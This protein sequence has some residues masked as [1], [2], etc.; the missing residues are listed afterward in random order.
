MGMNLNAA[1]YL[2]QRGFLTQRKNKLLD[3]G[4][5]NIYHVTEQQIVQFLRNQGVIDT[6]KVSEEINR[7][8]YFSTPRPDE[9]T[10]LLS[11]ITDLA[12][13]EYNSIDVCP[14]L[15]TEILDL[16]FDQIPA[17]L[18]GRYDVVLNFGTTEHIFNQWNCFEVIH[19]ALKAGG[20]VYHQLPSSGYLDHGYYC[21]TPLFFKE[22]AQANGYQ[23][24]ALEVTPAGESSFEG[25][26]IP[27]RSGD[28]LLHAPGSLNENDRVPATNMHVILRK[29]AD[30][31]FRVSLEI[32]TAHA[33]V[34]EQMAARYAAGAQA[35]AGLW[36][37]VRNTFR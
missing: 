25:L 5:Q 4:P 6:K 10:T 12:D 26:G 7:L 30:T 13:I 3:V 16:N 34:N 2:Q 28:T 24:E 19:D 9:R 23:I 8:V 17:R 37:R 36:R 29:V 31:R 15:K 18:R 11:E 22:I 1:I 35:A 33:P 27:S 21:Y 32:A 14:G 20:V